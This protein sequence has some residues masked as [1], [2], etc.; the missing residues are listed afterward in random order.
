MG[1]E[2]TELFADCSRE[3]IFLSCWNVAELVVK[4]KGSD[5]DPQQASFYRPIS[6]LPTLVKTLETLIV[7]RLETETG[8]NFG[9]KQHGFVVGRSTLTAFDAVLN[10]ADNCTSRYVVGMFLDITGAF[11]YLC[12]D[13]LIGD[14]ALLGASDRTIRVIRSYLSGK[15][16]RLTIEGHTV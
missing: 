6:L 2:I 4:L 14:L 12:W 13:N 1:K 7:F 15:K 11:D 8:H 3:S 5:K 9:V 16:A 10:W